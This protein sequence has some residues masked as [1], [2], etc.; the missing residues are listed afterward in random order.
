VAQD[1]GVLDDESADIRLVSS[2]ANRTKKHPNRNATKPRVAF[3]F[4][5]EEDFGEHEKKVLAPI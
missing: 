4:A 1:V 3:S 2:T 5:D